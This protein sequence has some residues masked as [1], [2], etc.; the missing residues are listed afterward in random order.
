MVVRAVSVLQV[1]AGHLRQTSMQTLYQAIARTK[2]A[3]FEGLLGG[4]L[5]AVIPPFDE[6]QWLYCLTIVK[7]N[8]HAHQLDVKWLGFMRPFLFAV[9]STGQ[10]DVWFPGSF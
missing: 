3:G 2:I 4:I 7:R 10:T 8:F 5:N 1:Y 6:V 9:P